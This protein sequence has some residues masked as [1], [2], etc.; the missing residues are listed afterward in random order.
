MLCRKCPFFKGISQAGLQ[1]PAVEL[2]LYPAVKSYNNCSSLRL[3]FVFAVALAPSR[4]RIF[5]SM[6][7]GRRGFWVTDSKKKESCKFLS[8]WTFEPSNA[9]GIWGI[10]EL[11]VV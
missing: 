7:C 5:W 11:Q 4:T 2:K 8:V 1:Q 10:G 6:H 9:H 3:E